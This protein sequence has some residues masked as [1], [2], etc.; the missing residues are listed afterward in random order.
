MLEREPR[1]LL[2]EL[3]EPPLLAALRRA[4]LDTRA[5]EVAEER[6]ERLGVRDVRGHDDLRRD[7]RRAAVV[8]DAERLEDRLA[9]L[10]LDVLEVERE[11]VDHLPVPERE[12]LD[13]GAV[14]L[15]GEPDH[16]DRADGALVGRLALREALDRMNSRFR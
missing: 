3:R 11:A 2:R 9:I 10:P 6:R 8:L 5:A 15:D 1:V 4:H 12:Q 14:A 7:R 13:R 16:V